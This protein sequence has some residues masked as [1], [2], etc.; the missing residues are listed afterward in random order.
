MTADDPRPVAVVDIDGVVAD[1]RHRL[2]FVESTPKDWDR[3]FAS[4]PDDPPLPAGVERV[5]Q[6]ARDHDVVFVTG[7]PER[8]RAATE[9]WLRD[10]GIGGWPVVMRGDHDRRPARQTKVHEVRAIARRTRVAV[11]VDDD[12][13][14]CAAMTAAG[15]AVEQ[16]DWMS[17]PPALHDAQE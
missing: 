2:R 10:A 5:Q 9:S 16:A 7:R 11:V 12:R 17:Q 1:V 15:F 3:F 4:A 13:E 8:C 14:V 6:L